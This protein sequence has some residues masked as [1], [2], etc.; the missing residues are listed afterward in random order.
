MLANHSYSHP[1]SQGITRRVKDPSSVIL[2]PELAFH[3]GP[4]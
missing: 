3:K 2:E 1:S 4:G